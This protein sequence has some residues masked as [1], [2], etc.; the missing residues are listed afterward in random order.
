MFKIS[1]K[2]GAQPFLCFKRNF[3]LFYINEITLI[4]AER[5]KGVMRGS[6]ITELSV[7]VGSLLVNDTKS[8]VPSDK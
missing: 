6:T 2:S 3:E 5:L 7:K 4:R 8:P 1:Q